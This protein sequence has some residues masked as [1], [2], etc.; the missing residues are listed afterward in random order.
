M[1]Q[2]CTVHNWQ[3]QAATGA[4]PTPGAAAC[5]TGAAELVAAVGPSGSDNDA[6][7]A[8]D[9]QHASPTSSWQSRQQA[10]FPQQGATMEHL[11]T[12]EQASIMVRVEVLCTVQSSTPARKRWPLK[13]YG[14]VLQV[15]CADS[16][17][18]RA[19]CWKLAPRPRRIGCSASWPLRCT[20][21]LSTLYTKNPT[22]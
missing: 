14:L 10:V 7:L 22:D 2:R 21:I 4:G 11:F 18:P 16:W 19:T 15:S 5:P 12:Q 3:L 8:S 6:R 1:L 17:W 13:A 20:K 9:L